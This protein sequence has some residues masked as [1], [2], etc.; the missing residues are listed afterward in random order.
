MK[1][2][3]VPLGKLIPSDEQNTLEVHLRIQPVAASHPII[4]FVVHHLLSRRKMRGMGE[5]QLEGVKGS[6][7]SGG[8]GRDCIPGEHSD[9]AAV[10]A[11]KRRSKR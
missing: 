10:E 8:P 7:D 2:L 6:E 11:A 1:I 4:Y 9:G 5:G 3:D